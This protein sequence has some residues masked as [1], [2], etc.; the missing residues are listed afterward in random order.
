VLSKPSTRNFRQNMPIVQHTRSLITSAARDPTHPS[1]DCS[2]EYS[3]RPRCTNPSCNWHRHLE[4]RFFGAAL[5]SL[6]PGSFRRLSGGS[7]NW[8]RNRSR[9]QPHLPTST[10]VCKALK[11][12]PLIQF[13]GMNLVAHQRN[14]FAIITAVPCLGAAKVYTMQLNWRSLII[15]WTADTLC[16]ILIIRNRQHRSH[17]EVEY[18][19][20]N[21]STAY[22]VTF[23][24]LRMVLLVA[25]LRIDRRL[26]SRYVPPLRLDPSLASGAGGL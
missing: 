25:L 1:A 19:F 23:S 9:P 2:N 20:N 13:L 18:V 4:A 26:P 24:G 12:E 7:V 3:H 16:V 21:G 14:F 5:S 15:P 6:Q 17:T 11:D 10:E 8:N 22:V